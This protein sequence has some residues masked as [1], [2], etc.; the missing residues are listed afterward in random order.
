[1]RRLTV[2]LLVLF[3]LTALAGCGLFQRRETPPPPTIDRS[4]RIEGIELLA[5]CRSVQFRIDFTQ[6]ASAPGELGCRV[7]TTSIINR[8]AST[9]E[10]FNLT[11]C[12]L[13]KSLKIRVEIIGTVG[14]CDP[15]FKAGDVFEF[16]GVL[17][18]AG[19]GKF[20]VPLSSFKRP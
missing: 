16:E 19:G 5:A 12:D 7:G 1:M 11:A 8:G 15:P 17:T 14:S 18:P 4:G 6:T 9:T 20:S 3:L 2:L 10:E 13:T